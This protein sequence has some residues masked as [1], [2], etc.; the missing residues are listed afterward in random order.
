LMKIIF[1]WM[2]FLNNSKSKINSTTNSTDFIRRKTFHLCWSFI[3]YI[4]SIT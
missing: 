1:S 3:R 2:I 4:S